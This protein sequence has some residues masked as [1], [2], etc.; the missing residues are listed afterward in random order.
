MEYG[1]NNE[2]N[3]EAC[4]LMSE[5]HGHIQKVLYPSG[6]DF[7]GKN[8]SVLLDQY[9]I[10]VE[11]SEQL[12]ARRQGVNT[13]F[14][15]INSLLLTGIGLLARELTKAP[16]SVFAALAI[17]VAGILLCLGWYRLLCSYAQLNHGKFV[18]IHELERHLPASLF[19]AEWEALGAG[20]NVKTY[21]PCTGTEKSIAVIFSVLY[22]VGGISSIA[23]V[24]LNQ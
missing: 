13:F 23:W 7:D 9:K 15:S 2:R 21:R 19:Q 10:F 14:L 22:A 20:R 18:V 12:V 11:T 4:S 3:K 17:C 8:L 1:L 16:A 5:E 24:L 6:T